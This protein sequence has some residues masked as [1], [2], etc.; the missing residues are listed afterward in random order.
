MCDVYKKYTL[1]SLV[2]AGETP[3][4]NKYSAELR[5]AQEANMLVCN[6]ESHAALLIDFL[7]L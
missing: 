3:C 5:C 7:R 4:K 1:L 2:S 6:T